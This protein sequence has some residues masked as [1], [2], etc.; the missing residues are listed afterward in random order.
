MSN[1]IT[2]A[3]IPVRVVRKAIQNLH[4]GVYPPDGRVRVAVP[5]NTTDDNARLAV[6]S[7]LSWIRKQQRSFQAQARQSE[8]EMLTGESHYVWGIRRLLTVVERRGCHQV[9][10]RARRLILYVNPGT[11]VANRRLAL[12][13]WY[14]DQLKAKLTALVS[15][16]EEVVGVKLAGWGVKR[17]KTKW[18]SCNIATRRIWLN[19][20]LAKKPPQCLEYVLVHE[21]VHLLERHHNDR[22]R[23]LLDEFLPNWPKIRTLLNREPLGDEEWG[24][25]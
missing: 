4:L 14:R 9:E 17:M 16:C 20:E 22:F 18:G 21:L 8:R 12:N 23:A 19:L 5:L 7:R 3:G 13:E 11:T 2:V 24:C 15:G 6:A 10:I 25:G 1:T